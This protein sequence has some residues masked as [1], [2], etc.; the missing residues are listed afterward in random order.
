MNETIF[1]VFCT[2]AVIE[3]LSFLAGS[4]GAFRTVC[5]LAVTLM[6]ISSA[7]SVSGDVNFD[8]DR[9]F[10]PDIDIE[11]SYIAETQLILS[12]KIKDT[13]ASAEIYDV[14]PEVILSVDDN[15]E[16]KVEELKVGVSHSADLQRAKVIVQNLFSDM[17]ETE[18]YVIDD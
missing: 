7:V 6:L 16:V 12:T 2:V 17:A 15:Y 1:T 14:Y 18:V 8:F 9:S 3:L 10:E 4:E 11:E 5:S 13:L